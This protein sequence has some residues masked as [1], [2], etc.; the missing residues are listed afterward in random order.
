MLFSTSET[1]NLCSGQVSIC[2][3]TSQKSTF[4]I[5][6]MTPAFRSPVRIWLDE[7]QNLPL[8]VDFFFFFFVKF[9]GRKCRKGRA[10]GEV[11][12]VAALTQS[13]SRAVHPRRRR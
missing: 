5:P 12:L 13:G 1:A 10:G 8:K 2:W 9:L 3:K 7:I 11:K 6:A 4:V